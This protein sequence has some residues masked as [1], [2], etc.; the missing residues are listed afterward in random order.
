MYSLL[1]ALVIMFQLCRYSVIHGPRRAAQIVNSCREQHPENESQ[2]NARPIQYIIRALLIVMAVL[3]SI[4]LFAMKGVAWTQFFGACYLASYMMNAI[5]NIFG[6]PPIDLSQEAQPLPRRGDIRPSVRISHWISISAYTLQ[7]VI[8]VV[9]LEPA[10]PERLSSL[11][12]NVTDFCL[13]PLHLLTAVV[14]IPVY[15][16]GWMIPFAAAPL[17]VD[18]ILLCIPVAIILT[19]LSVELVVNKPSL[20]GLL[21]LLFAV[22]EATVM[23]VCGVAAFIGFTLLRL[24]YIHFWVFQY[25]LDGVGTEVLVGWMFAKAWVAVDPYFVMLTLILLAGFLSYLV[26]RLFMFGILARPFRLHETKL[27]NNLAWACMFLFCTNVV[28]ALL[29]YS[30]VYDPQNTYRPDWVQRLP[31]AIR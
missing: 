26:Q 22:D 9:A 14:W 31:R 28:A 7:V 17:M 24:C 18:I 29:Y 25:S 4:K 16:F 2:G 27:A 13:L 1:D 19:I 30:K 6:K 20:A 12:D 10:M 21:G 15:F 3:Q 11:P 8:W 23:T 5:T